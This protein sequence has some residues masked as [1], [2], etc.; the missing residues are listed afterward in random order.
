MYRFLKDV[1]EMTGL[2]SRCQQVAGSSLSRK[3]QNF[4]IPILLLQLYREIYAV[5]SRRF[6]SMIANWGSTVR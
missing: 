1:K 5:L 4:A 2:P 3:E 6:T